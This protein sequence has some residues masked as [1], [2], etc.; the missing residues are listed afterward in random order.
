MAETLVATLSPTGAQQTVTIPS[1]VKRVRIFCRGANGSHWNP[2]QIYKNIIMTD[3]PP[4]QVHGEFDVTPGEVLYAYV[5]GVATADAGNENALRIG[6]FNGGGN[7]GYPTNWRPGG[8]YEIASQCGGGGGGASDVRR[9]G[10]AL[11]NRIIVAGGGAGGS[12]SMGTTSNSHRPGGG[13]GTSG[14]DAKLAE[15]TTA[16][17]VKGLGGTQSA[18]GGGF[19]SGIGGV[20][21]AGQNYGGTTVGGYSG[22]GGAGGYYGG[23][24]GVANSDGNNATS[25]G[26]G[27]GYVASTVV[28]GTAKNLRKGDIGFVDFTTAQP[29]LIEVYATAYTPD[30]PTPLEPALGAV[31][32]RRQTLKFAW[33]FNDLDPGDTQS[34][35]D[36]QYRAQGTAPWTI[37]SASTDQTNTTVA[38][39]TFAVGVWEWQVRA[40][41]QAGAAGPYST[42]STFQAAEPPAAPS[43]TAPTLNQEITTSSLTINWTA[44]V[45]SEGQA[46]VVADS[47]GSPFPSSVVAGPVTVGSAIRTAGLTL[48][49]PGNYYHAQVRVKDS[50]GL[51]SDWASRRFLFNAARPPAPSITANTVS[52]AGGFRSLTISFPASVAPDEPTVRY[53]VERRLRASTDA[54]A[55]I[56]GGASANGTSSTFYDFGVPSGIAHEYR[57]HSFSAA[58]GSRVSGISNPTTTLALTGTWLHS[59]EDP[60][61][62]AYNFPYNQNG[63]DESWQAEVS[64]MKVAGRTR[65]VAEFGESD[66]ESMDITLQLDGT[67]QVAALRNLLRRKEVLCFRDKYGRLLYGIVSSFPISPSRWGGVTS[68]TLTA[69]DFS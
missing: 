69:V 62:T 68:F 65:P 30:A 24:S 59:V 22:G 12:A 15:F 19:A 7:G 23:G 34:R 14:L 64:L 32:D 55:Y 61:G 36:L 50:A 16:G 1:N 18:G 20:G 35:F 2:D 3:S 47:A 39:L 8:F 21:A 31:I 28:P 44:T 40:Y 4:G 57:V 52:S 25:G 51:W 9:G 43:I 13:G 53:T 33:S 60:L 42:I 63:G 46:R 41:D 37:I 48:T 54:W 49:N 56:G 67:A 10:T 26:G 45:Q 11:T 66:D 58:G 17:T 5:G 27:A 38:A 29:A 6:G